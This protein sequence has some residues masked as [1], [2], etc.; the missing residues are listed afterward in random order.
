MEDRFKN[1]VCVGIMLIRDKKVLLMKRKNT[2]FDDG[3]YELP[4]GHLE[5]NE[6]LYDAMKAYSLNYNK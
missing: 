3:M 6:D 2:G 1:G 5:S 4:G